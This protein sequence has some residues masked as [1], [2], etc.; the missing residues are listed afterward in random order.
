MAGLV[1]PHNLLPAD[2][3]FG[4]GPSKVRP[5][6]VARPRGVGAA[7]YL[8]TSHRQA[9]VRDVVARLALRPRR[10]VR[11]ARRAT[12]SRSATAARRRSGTRPPSV[13][14]RRRS[15]HLSFGEFSAKF[16]ECTRA[17]PFL[18]EPRGARLRTGHLPAA[19]RR[20]G[21]GRLLPDPQRDLDRGTG[22]PCSRPR[23]TDGV[24]GGRPRPR[25]RDLGGRRLAGR[26]R[27]SSTCTTS[28]R[29]SASG[30]KAGSGWRCCP[31]PRSSASSASAATG[32][33]VPGL[34]GPE[35][36][37]IAQLTPAT[38]LQHA[39]SGHPVP[40]GR[41]GGLVPRQ[42]RPRVGRLADRPLRRG[43][44]RLGRAARASRGRS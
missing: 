9:R 37:P 28:P 35:A 19:G 2:G 17:A 6:S 11:P 4:S 14:S 10:A 5:E 15:Q 41:A 22:A 40:A 7:T 34:F 44:L 43:R 24:V 42:R 21:R 33:F 26:G 32:R 30:P 39:G 31:R 29:R 8:G 18:D 13:S 20:P 1:I 3:R 12:R 36:S 38:D 16:A 25:R 27:A 23:R